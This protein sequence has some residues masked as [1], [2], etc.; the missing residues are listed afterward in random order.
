MRS[1]AANDHYILIVQANTDEIPRVET[2]EGEPLPQG[3]NPPPQLCGLHQAEL[4]EEEEF[5]H[6][7]PSGGKDSCR[8]ET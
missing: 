5:R 8:I 6:Q 3:H 4:Q 2:P 7:S 1:F